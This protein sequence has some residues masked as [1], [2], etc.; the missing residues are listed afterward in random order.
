L[1]KAT[2]LFDE[3]GQ[4]AE[5]QRIAEELMKS[6]ATDDPMDA[7]ERAEAKHK[8]RQKIRIVAREKEARYRR[9]S[10]DPFATME[11]LGLPVRPEAQASLKFKATDKQVAYLEKAGVTD[12]K[13]MSK[14]RASMMI[15]AIS[16]RRDADLATIKQTAWLIN[17]GVEPDEARKMTRTA[18]SEFL[19]EAF[20][21]NRR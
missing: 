21:R 7:I 4:D 15:D 12:A 2:E 6:G 18:A 1:V 13:S 17:Q 20:G 14:R 9:V 19:S 16:K 5:V 8:E 10:Y 3:T 11:T